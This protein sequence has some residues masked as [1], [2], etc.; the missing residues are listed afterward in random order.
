VA[1]AVVL[2]SAVALSAVPAGAVPTCSFDAQTGAVTVVVGTGETAV[3]ARAGD[4]IALDGVPCDTATVTTTDSIS[5]DGSAGGVNVTIDLS[6]GP[7]EPGMTPD[8]DGTSEIEF[9]LTVPGPSNVLIAGSAEA[10]HIVLGTDGANLNA[11]ETTGDSDV[12]ISGTPAVTIEGNAGTDTLSVAGGAGTGAPSLA[13][14]AGGADDDDLVGGLG[15][16]AFDGGDGV[17][18]LDYSAASGVLADLAGGLVLHA[19]GGQDTVASVEDLLGSP[20]ADVIVGTGQANTLTGADGD[21][22]IE[23]GGGDDALDGGAGVD[24]V[25]FR[26]AVVVDL[27]DG[28]ASGDGNDAL[29]AFENVMGSKKADT[30]R[31]DDGRNKLAG[32]SGADELFGQGGP[33]LLTGGKGNDRLN[34]Q[35]GPDALFGRAGRDQLDGGKAND[36]CNGGPDPDSFVNCERI[37]LD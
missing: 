31:G 28:T 35:D 27:G 33:D 20:A 9:V 10:D 12:V 34:G 1:A 19:A 17:D 4:A 3:I 16:S 26:A 22:R 37:R 24:T 23:G 8:P 32:G 21:D 18:A 11:A 36:S 15:G 13:S 25:R 30:I 14:V 6:G 29:T 2:G 5:V 7:F